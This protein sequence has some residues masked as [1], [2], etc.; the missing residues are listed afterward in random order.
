MQDTL[1]TMMQSLAL[2]QRARR[3]VAQPV[4][5]IVDQCIFFNVGVGG[6]NVGFRLIIIVIRDKVLDR[7]VREK[8][9]KFP[10]EL[11]GQRFV[12]SKNECR[13]LQ[14]L[15]YFGHGEGLAGPG[16]TK[17]HLVLFAIFHTLDQLLNRVGLVPARA[18]KEC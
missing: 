8:R 16:D 6:R 13:T 9:L 12:V 11:G 17:Q 14:C 5:F 10:I 4:D 15:D 7:I 2:K 3:R 1:A 18:E